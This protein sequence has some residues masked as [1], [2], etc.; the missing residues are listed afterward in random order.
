M[1]CN[2]PPRIVDIHNLKTH[3]DDKLQK[4]WQPAD[5]THMRLEQFDVTEG[6]LTRVYFRQIHL[7]PGPQHAR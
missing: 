6:V 7:D 2:D 4:L 1:L 3:F 5:F